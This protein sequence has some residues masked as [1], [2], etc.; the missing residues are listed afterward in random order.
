[1]Q[2]HYDHEGVLTGTTITYRESMWDEGARDRAIALTAYEDGLCSCC[3]I[4]VE[5]A[6]DP[7][8][9]WDVDKSICYARRAINKIESAEKKNHENDPEGWDA[10]H[11]YYARP[12]EDDRVT[13]KRGKRGD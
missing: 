13:K 2:E 5:Q 10:G 3:G 9:V 11:N 12:V 1:V 8:Q 4:P 6:Y 7:K